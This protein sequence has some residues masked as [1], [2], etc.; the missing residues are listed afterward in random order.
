MK[1]EPFI[2]AEERLFAKNNFIN[3]R[4]TA[5]SISRNIEENILAPW[6]AYTTDIAHGGY[7]TAFDRKWKP[8]DT[9]KNVW[10]H[11]RQIYTFSTA[12]QLLGKKT[13]YYSLAKQGRD[14]LI[15]NAYAGSGKWHYLLSAQGKVLMKNHSVFTDAFALLGLS[16]FARVFDNN[17]DL[18]LIKE[19]F[20]SVRSAIMNKNN[21][22]IYPQ[23]HIHGIM[24]HGPYMIALN[25]TSTASSV[26]DTHLC[27][28]LAVFCAKTIMEKFYY[29]GKVYELC[30][31]NG[32]LLDTEEGHTI[33]PGHC[34][35]SMWFIINES[36]L[37]EIAK[38]RRRALKVIR[39]IW[40]QARDDEYGGLLH[41]LDDREILSNYKDWNRK[42]NLKATD[43]VWWTHAEALYALLICAVLDR[44]TE[45]WDGFCDLYTWCCEYFMD[46]VYGE[47]YMVLN[48]DGSP[49]I[50]DK[51]GL[52]KAAFHIPRAFFMCKLLLDEIVSS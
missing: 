49:R 31:T 47:W 15:K 2:T 14:W 34:F 3:I 17:D 28:N 1:R 48:R 8:T 36:H 27:E 20:N 32:S 18:P 24:M 7:Q 42:R 38:Y 16:Q 29:R 45:M 22:Y 11:A 5:Q 40:Y 44:D 13:I 26:I 19:T 46:S 35:E 30:D 10:M 9:D 50:T 6:C 33:N 41:M 23:E 21:E 52:Q 25:A 12:Y 51:G 4:K 39:N 37:P 43:K